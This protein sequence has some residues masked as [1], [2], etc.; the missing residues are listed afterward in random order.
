MYSKPF[1]KHRI[2]KVMGGTL[3]LLFSCLLI[4]GCSQETVENQGEAVVPLEDKNKAAIRAVIE[5]E[6]TV[7]NEEYIQIQK[8]LLNKSMELYEKGE[9]EGVT[10]TSDPLEGTPELAAYNEFMK[11]TYEPY[12]MDYAFDSFTRAFAFS[13]HFFLAAEE[14]FH[15]QMKVTDI[16]VVQSENENTPKAYDFTAQ[17]EFK[18]D[19]EE[20][21]QIEI[22]GM[23]ICSQEGKIGRIEFR[24]TDVLMKKIN[25]DLN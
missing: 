5:Q 8:N 25:E 12:F 7:P 15:Y 20:I 18:N 6:F 23:A 1:S 2:M 3:F 10:Y 11:K 21:T 16:E 13:Y 19:L 14:D 24:G 4:V 17:V 22:S 9:A